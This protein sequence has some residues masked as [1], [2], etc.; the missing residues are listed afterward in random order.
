M[1]TKM[2]KWWQ[3]NT[4]RIRAQYR[5]LP[6]YRYKALAARCRRKGLVFSISFKNYKKKLLAGCYYCGADLSNEIGGGMDRRNNDNRTYTARNLVACCA[7]CNN[8]K[9]KEL[10]EREMIHV[11]KALKSFRKKEKKND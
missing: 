1:K 8:I 2:Q 7:K 3:K 4:A 5:V 6:E 11:M 10:T 9:S